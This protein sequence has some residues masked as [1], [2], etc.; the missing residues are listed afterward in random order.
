MNKPDFI[1]EWSQTFDDNCHYSGT[2]YRQYSASEKD[3]SLELLWDKLAKDSEQPLP[4]Y[5]SDIFIL[6]LMHVQKQYRSAQDQ[7]DHLEYYVR[8]YEAQQNASAKSPIGK[9][10]P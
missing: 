1:K 4:D 2:G 6:A 5:K 3:T 9:T 10:V 8:F 7:A